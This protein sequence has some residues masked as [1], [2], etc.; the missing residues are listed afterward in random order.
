[1][2][3]RL[4]D[5]H[6]HILYGIDDGSKTIDESIEMI[7]K[8]KGIGFT[9]IIITPHYIEGTSYDADNKTKTKLLNSIKN[10]AR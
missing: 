8:M 7:K 3:N 4:I 5:V 1:M 6:C 10:F 9:D 2:N